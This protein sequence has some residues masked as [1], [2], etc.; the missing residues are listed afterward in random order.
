MPYIPERA[1]LVKSWKQK[2]KRVRHELAEESLDVEV[3]N[4]IDIHNVNTI[5]RAQALAEKTEKRK[6]KPIKYH[7][8]DSEL[9]KNLID[10]G[11]MVDNESRSRNL[12]APSIR[13][14]GRKSRTPSTKPASTSKLSVKIASGS[15]ATQSPVPGPS[16]S[17]TLSSGSSSKP[18]SSLGL[19]ESLSSQ[20][21]LPVSRSPRPL[22]TRA[23]QA[24]I[25]SPSQ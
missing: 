20:S 3:G 13:V 9:D 15:R 23:L 18:P 11:I 1:D 22:P 14:E 6:K 5:E 12:R 19:R 25:L 17:M 8:W 7:N 16:R 24:P 10:K 21:S 4:D 2:Q